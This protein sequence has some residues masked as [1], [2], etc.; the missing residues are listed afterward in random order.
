M[1]SKGDYIWT[2]IGKIG[3]QTIFL[4]T[5]IILA[6][7]LSPE[8]FG[9]IGVLTIFL[10]IATTLNDAGFGGALIVE[11]DVTEK[12][13]YTVG[14]YNMVVSA[15]LY[16]ILFFIAPYLEHFFNVNGLTDITR[17]LSLVLLINSLSTVPKALMMKRLMFKKLSLISFISVLVSSILAIIGA[18]YAL[19]AFALV[20]YQIS[21]S[22]ITLIY[23]FTYTDY[24]IRFVFSFSSFKKLFSFGFYTTI[25]SIVDNI[26]ENLLSF[27]F[28]KFQNIS[29]VGFFVQ[30]KKLDD[31]GIAAVKDTINTVS[32][33]ILSTLKDDAK[34]FDEECSSILKMISLAV[35]PVFLCISVFSKEIILLT[36]GEKWIESSFY[37]SVLMIAGVFILLEGAYRNFIKAQGYVAKLFLYTLIKR[38]IG[39]SI[40]ITVAFINSALMIYGFVIGTVIGLITN[41]I[42]YSRL[43][44]ANTIKSIFRIIKVITPAALV[45]IISMLL[46]ASVDDQ[47]ICIS[48]TILLWIVYYVLILN[49]YRPNLISKLK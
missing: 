42:L 25:S 13:C 45:Y 23:V 39:I 19:G 4:I 30:A 33:P 6:R 20:I 44:S 36:F 15:F 5:T 16:S 40:I 26:Y 14:V 29:Q 35:V 1:R 10:S 43:L 34:V 31:A 22:V 7:Y 46:N 3:P 24:K 18:Y 49:H 12:D 27:L 17:W 47:K 41:I 38:I 11:K 9:K 28:G 32:F 2:L 37:L 8:E 48:I 21:I